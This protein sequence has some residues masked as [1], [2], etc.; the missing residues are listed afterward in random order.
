MHPY[1]PWVVVAILVITFLDLLV[2]A[3]IIKVG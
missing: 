1:V 3:N 2:D